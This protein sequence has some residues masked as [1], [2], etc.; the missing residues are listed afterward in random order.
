[1]KKGLL[2]LGAFS[3]LGSTLMAGGDIAPV[4]PAV[5]VPVVQEKSDRGFYAGIA[6]SY[7]SHDIDQAG[8]FIKRELD[9][10]AVTL[11][12]GYQY[13]KYIAAELRYITTIGDTDI[14]EYA[15]SADATVWALYLKPMLNLSKRA[16]IYALLGYADTDASNDLDY[17][18][19][20][21][22]NGFSWGAGFSLDM[23]EDWTLFTEYT[24]FYD[25]TNNHYDHAV[26]SVNFGV[27]YRF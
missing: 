19:S 2:V 16:K 25:D 6:Y 24:R 13:N 3:V 12:A 8:A 17:D 22:D 11:E 18:T 7:F 27:S 1:M 20:V 9:F 10:H 21:S 14:D 26:D 23:T 5:A 4:E 15:N